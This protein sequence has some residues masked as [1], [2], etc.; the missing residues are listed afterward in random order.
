MRGR[1]GPWGCL[2]A[3]LKVAA[4]LRPR[5]CVYAEKVFS[6]VRGKNT[7]G[8]ICRGE[9]GELSNEKVWHVHARPGAHSQQ[10]KPYLL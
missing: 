3:K 8:N 1:A 5:G 7:K 6:R 2:E 9:A 4:E 10:Q